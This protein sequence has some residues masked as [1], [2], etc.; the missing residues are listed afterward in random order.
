MQYFRSKNE[1]RQIE[2]DKAIQMNI[3]NENINEIHL[4]NEVY[5]DL[6]HLKDENQKIKQSI[7][8]ERISINEA[9][10]Y[11]YYNLQKDDI[12]I[13]SNT[14]IYFDDSLTLL[15]SIYICTYN[16]NDNMLNRLQFY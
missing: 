11:S 7:L 10:K 6:S 8:N 4:L 16:I 9:M 1:T 3:M 14:D 12:V 5:Y 13:I 15:F 2:I